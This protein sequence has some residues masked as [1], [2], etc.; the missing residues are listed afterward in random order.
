MSRN[1][2]PPTPD[3]IPLLVGIGCV[4]AV[5]WIIYCALVK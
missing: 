5:G 2:Y 3:L 1:V 4:V